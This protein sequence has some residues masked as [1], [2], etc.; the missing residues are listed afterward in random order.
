MPV[1]PAPVWHLDW[2]TMSGRGQTD[3]RGI[4]WILTDQ[5]GFWDSP[6]ARVDVTDRSNAHGS[7]VGPIYYKERVITLKGRVFCDDPAVLRRYW[8]LITGLCADPNASY[9]LACHSQLGTLECS[10]R[11]DGQ[12]LTTPA[13]FLNV[14]AFDFSVQLIAAD[15]R[16]YSD[17]K[18]VMR[19]N[20]PS[21][22]SGD[23]LN[24]T[25]GTSPN[26]G[27]EFDSGQTGLVF[28]MQNSSG[29]LQ[30]TN[31]GTAPTVPTYELYG[32]L[33]TPT[34]T[35]WS[36]TGAASTMTYNDTIN[37]G[38]YVTIDPREPAVLLGGT[39][40]RRWLLNPAQFAG[41]AIPAA[42]PATNQPGYLAVG[43]T[44]DGEA[45]AGGYLT[46]T[47]AD[48]YF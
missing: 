22:T 43:L 39:A 2:L 48:A 45:A 10:V 6:D 23:G 17:Q 1:G 15:P 16:K 7:Y 36:P 38:E 18:R 12:V 25:A 30:L 34:V 28:G 11:R 32:P 27:L 14:E 13:P 3:Q 5:T 4:Q 26:V 21:A 44:H 35:C 9:R 41:F 29:L 47:F 37:E 20:L 24:F 19:A 40:S 31:D 46:A 8:S 33:T 42:D